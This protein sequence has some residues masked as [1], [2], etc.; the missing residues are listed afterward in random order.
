MT[1]GVDAATQIVGLIGTDVTTG[2][3]V[4]GFHED[5]PNEGMVGP[6]DGADIPKDAIAALT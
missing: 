6:V 4:I 1:A 5:I 2:D 3:V